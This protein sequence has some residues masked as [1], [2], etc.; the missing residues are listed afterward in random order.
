MLRPFPRNLP[1]HV[2]EPLFLDEY[3]RNMMSQCGFAIFISG[4]SRS[5]LISAGVME[6][7]KIARALRKIPIAIGATGFAAAKIWDEVGKEREP[8][9]GGAVSQKLYGYLNDSSLSNE[10]ILRAVF[11]IME[12]MG[13]L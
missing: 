2:S 13:A 7:Y 12:R 4:T 11:T 3:R 10:E 8:V 6:E 5:T 1:S 9:Y